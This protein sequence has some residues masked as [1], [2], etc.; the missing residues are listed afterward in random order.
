MKAKKQTRP[1][2]SAAG[3]T[4]FQEKNQKTKPKNDKEDRMLKNSSG[5]K[6]NVKLVSVTGFE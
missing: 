2:S 5:I 3:K 1:G 4:E 6:F